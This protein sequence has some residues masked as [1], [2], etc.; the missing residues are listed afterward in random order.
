MATFL[1]VIGAVLE[2]FGFLSVAFDLR[3]VGRESKELRRIDKVVMAEAALAT[4]DAMAAEGEETSMGGH[5]E[6]PTLEDRVKRLETEIE[7]VVIEL[8]WLKRREE[9]RRRRI[10]TT[11]GSWVDHA[12]QEAYDLV[13]ETRR[14]LGEAIGGR[15]WLRWVGLGVF[16]LGL[17]VQ[18]WGNVI[19]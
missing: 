7:A 12:Q 10:L 4:A 5:P 2:G 13:Q 1:I 9:K 15:I 19:S 8:G 16:A 14:T 3:S 17:G 18:T 11:T 6:V